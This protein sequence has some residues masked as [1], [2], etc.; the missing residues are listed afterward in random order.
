MR[1]DV[2]FLVHLRAVSRRDVRVPQPA[3]SEVHYGLAR[4]APSRR[5][6]ELQER[7]DLVSAELE[8][9]AWTDAVSEAFGTIKAS[10]ARQGKRLEDFDI[11]IAAHAV[12]TGATLVTADSKHMPR[13][14]GL[15]V[16]DWMGGNPTTF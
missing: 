9:C 10:L 12:A 11:A 1:G 7:F 5:K 13:I 4:L 2:R 3:L 14:S 6:T 16:E 15:R 8:R